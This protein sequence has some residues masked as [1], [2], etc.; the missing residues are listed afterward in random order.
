M[1]APIKKINYK[2]EIAMQYPSATVKWFTLYQMEVSSYIKESI[3]Y[4]LNILVK[5]DDDLCPQK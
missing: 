3:C 2:I 4:G 1:G 5:Y